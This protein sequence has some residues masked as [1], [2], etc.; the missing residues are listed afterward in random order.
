MYVIQIVFLVYSLFITT[1]VA[2][3]FRAHVLFYDAPGLSVLMNTRAL[4]K[5]VLSTAGRRHV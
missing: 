2:F 4:R 1:A 3:I 5:V